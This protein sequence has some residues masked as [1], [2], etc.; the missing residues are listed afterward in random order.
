M[1][2]SLAIP[3]LILVLSP[4]MV[5]VVKTQMHLQSFMHPVVVVCCSNLQNIHLVQNAC[6][7]YSIVVILVNILVAH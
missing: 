4:W 1:F 6:I 7:D 5:S 3:C 2:R